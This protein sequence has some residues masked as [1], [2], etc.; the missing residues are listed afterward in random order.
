[1]PSACQ[2][3]CG[4]GEAPLLQEAAP[5]SAAPGFCSPRATRAPLD[6]PQTGPARDPVSP[7]WVSIH[8]QQLVAPNSPPAGS[9]SSTGL[10]RGPVSHHAQAKAFRQQTALLQAPPTTALSPRPLQGASWRLGWGK[11]PLPEVASKASGLRVLRK[12]QSRGPPGP[13]CSHPWAHELP[14]EVKRPP[15]APYPR[16]PRKSAGTDTGLSHLL[17]GQ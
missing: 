2:P 13:G 16:A 12:G 15:A 4:G 6:L 8:A 10:C 14:R 5:R 9:C 3:L 1:M 11:A 7:G 17:G